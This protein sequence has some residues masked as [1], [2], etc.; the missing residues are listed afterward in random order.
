M[1]GYALGYFGNTP[2]EGIDLIDDALRLNPNSAQALVYGGW[3]RLYNGDAVTAKVHFERALRLSPLDISVYRT[4][5]G[6]A[7]SYLFLRQF[8]DAV[9][10]ASKALHHNS[11]F[12]AT[13]RV[14]AA[15]LGHAGRLDE[16]RQ[17][18]EQLQAL[19]PGLTV[20]RFGNE[21]RFRH[22]EYF[23]LLMD[24]LRKAGLPK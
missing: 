11:K 16:A 2:E 5:A 8:D 21:T 24:G 4:Y 13:H 20:T 23:E 14:L 19:V 1:A 22:P 3:L 6:S 18:V 10:W 17:V 9:S 12:T 15:S 7:F